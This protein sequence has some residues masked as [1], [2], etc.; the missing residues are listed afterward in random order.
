MSL[1]PSNV[2]GATSQLPADYYFALKSDIPAPQALSQTGNTVSLSGGGGSVNIST[3]TTVAAT[4]QKT[5]AISYSGGLLA[6]N[7]DGLLTIGEGSAIG[8]TRV[9][10]GNII[11]QRDDDLPALELVTGP[12]SA[13][14]AFDGTKI[15][16]PAVGISGEIY[17]SFG[18]AGAAGQQLQSSGPGLPWVWGAGSGVGLTAVVAGS[19]IGVDNTN[20]I[21]PIVNVE[22]SSTLDMSGQDI[23]GA[24]SITASSD[25]VTTRNFVAKESLVNTQPRIEFQDTTGFGRAEVGWNAATDLLTMGGNEVSLSTYNDKMYFTMKPSDGYIRTLGRGVPVRTDIQDAAGTVTETIMSVNGNGQVSIETPVS[26]TGVDLGYNTVSTY[27]IVQSKGRPLSIAQSAA[28]AATDYILMD[29][30]GDGTG[31]LTIANTEYVDINAG[32]E[33]RLTTAEPIRMT[34]PGETEL[35]VD[36]AGLVKITAPTNSDD[37]KLRLENGGGKGGEIFTSE[38][39]GF[40]AIQA[41]GGYNLTMESTG[42]SV[43]VATA[44]PDTNVA[45]STNGGTASITAS[46]VG[47]VGNIS[48]LAS[49]PGS[50]NTVSLTADPQ[51]GTLVGSAMNGTTINGPFISSFDGAAT[52]AEMGYDPM[53]FNNFVAG[54]GAFFDVK[55]SRSDPK[56]IRFEN[57]PAEKVTV[58]A[59]TGSIELLADS[60]SVG[61]KLETGSAY[62]GLLS[63]PN[64]DTGL[65][66]NAGAGNPSAQLVIDTGTSKAGLKYDGSSA[67]PVQFHFDG[68]DFISGSSS[69]SSG[70]HLVIW[71]NGTQY[72]I[73]LENP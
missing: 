66:V 56:V 47:G 57:S 23:S 10:G 28:L 55:Q 37:A 48:L 7:I 42:G 49:D 9:E 40:M 18:S 5:T 8:A 17:D 14:V 43:G 6:T 71:V 39:G 68:G 2:A 12:A 29:T 35:L 21:A 65:L 58:N 27:S 73:K 32:K 50:G 24:G 16:M 62:T 63:G 51:L 20:P 44:A 46:D 22:I 34:V 67:T 60:G 36:T 15:L 13:S 38:T 26:G 41:G 31:G 70:Q 72:K 11:V 4:A 53:T 30:V 19:N 64:P 33:I 54:L 3:T 25:I 61:V 52:G 1:V 45:I 59:D 69:G